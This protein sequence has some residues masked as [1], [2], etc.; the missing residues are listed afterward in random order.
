MTARAGSSAVRRMGRRG[1][2]GNYCA[3]LAIDNMGGLA[4]ATAI[5]QG[6][7]SEPSMSR[8][9]VVLAMLGH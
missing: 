5:K 7:E 4:A 9:G 2:I 3:S 6:A 8:N 1:N